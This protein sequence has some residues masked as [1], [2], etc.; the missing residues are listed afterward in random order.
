MNRKAIGTLVI[1][2]AVFVGT[3]AASGGCGS[4]GDGSA[5]TVGV[6]GVESERGGDHSSELPA[7][8]GEHTTSEET[9][10]PGEDHPTGEKTESGKSPCS[11]APGTLN[12]VG[13]R[14]TGTGHVICH[15][16][17]NMLGG[18]LVLAFSHFQGG[19]W[20]FV[21]DSRIGVTSLDIGKELTVSTN[22]NEGLWLVYWE[23]SGTKA[24][25]HDFTDVYN[26]PAPPKRID[27]CP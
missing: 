13:N 23:G 4:G 6:G 14:V 25:G 16:E 3:G 27:S 10:A 17:P 11:F 21:E 22:C 8:S 19:S 1:A 24:N 9:T 20:E 15:E 18:T 2:A 26:F 12:V 5:P 7:S